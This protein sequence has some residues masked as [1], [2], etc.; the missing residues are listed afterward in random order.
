MA[1][2]GA[3]LNKVGFATK[4]SRTGAV[5]E[6]TTREGDSGARRLEG[7]RVSWSLRSLA[8]P[9]FALSPFRRPFKSVAAHLFL[10]TYFLIGPFTTDLTTSYPPAMNLYLA[11]SIMRTLLDERPKLSL[12]DLELLAVPLRSTRRLPLPLSFLQWPS[13]T[14]PMDL[15]MTPIVLL[16]FVK[17]SARNRPQIIGRN[18]HG[19]GSRTGRRSGFLSRFWTS[20]KHRDQMHPVRRIRNSIPATPALMY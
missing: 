10:R 20:S 7:C 15:G 13:H 12:S 6:W 18:P 19:L 14:N 4:Q 16:F 11:L 9:T 3:L 8:A 17:F 2:N 1:N 5:D